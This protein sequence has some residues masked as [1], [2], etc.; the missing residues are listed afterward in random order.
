MMWVMLVV[1]ATLALSL[2][3]GSAGSADG[4]RSASRDSAGGNVLLCLLDE[5]GVDELST[6]GEHP[7]APATPT[8]DALAAG[9]VLFR[10]AYAYPICS[11]TRAAI[12]TGR[13]GFRTGINNN[14]QFPKN[15]WA[16][17]LDEVTLPELLALG[18]GGAYSSAIVG[19]WHLA[20]QA[21][22]GVL[23]PFLQGFQHHRG[24]QTNFS[25]PEDYFNW[26]KWVAGV[27]STST[28]YAT[29]DHVDDALDLATTLPQPWFVML[30]TT[31]AHTPFHAPP[32]ALHTYTLSGDPGLTPVEHFDAAVQALDTELGRLLASIPADVLANTTVLVMGD[33]GAPGLAVSPPSI[34]SQSKGTLFEGAINVPLI[35]WGRGV[36][37]AGEECGALV[38]ATD[39]FATVADLAGFD[40]AQAMPPNRPLDS[41]SLVPYFEDPHRAPLY[42]YVYA[43]KVK[44]T[45]AIPTQHVFGQSSPY[46]YG[47]MIRDER[48]KL[49]V[50][51]GN[52]DHFYDLQGLAFEGPNLLEGPLTPEQA[53]ALARLRKAMRELREPELPTQF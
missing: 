31:A 43:E 47:R 40:A 19:K 22:G 11:P 1:V 24:V 45:G 10:N 28:T 38:S 21:V 39:L 13:H 16:L 15:G 33:N 2:G 41:V 4:P 53:K 26:T 6:Y 17:A 35:A 14:V 42:Q 49:I 51:Q 12:L 34:P 44:P 27:P 7:N 30:S 25:P 32:Q 48:W 52:N 8:L 18:T 50:R 46:T 9:G 29:T 3:T 20:S 23:H 36:P 5:V 37:A